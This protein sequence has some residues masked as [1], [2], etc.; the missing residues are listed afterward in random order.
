LIPACRLE[1]AAKSS[2]TI[3]QP[4]TLNEKGEE[5]TPKPT[6]TVKTLKTKGD[7]VKP[8]V[9]PLRCCECKGDQTLRDC[10]ATSDTDKKAIVKKRQAE[11]KKR[12]A[13]KRQSQQGPAHRA[14][15]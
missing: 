12:E 9:E 1:K 15:R 6:T 13:G 4:S 5:V 3:K 11:K 14:P 7:D 2:S 8:T 10:T